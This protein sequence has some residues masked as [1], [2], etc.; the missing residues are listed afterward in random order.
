[1]S[2]AAINLKN[3]LSQETFLE[4]NESMSKSFIFLLSSLCDMI[5]DQN[6]IIQKFTDDSQFATKNDFKENEKFIKSVKEEIEAS[7]K[8][9]H[10]N[11]Q[12]DLDSNRAFQA[13]RMNDFDKQ[14]KSI[15]QTIHD[16][17]N[18]QFDPLQQ[19][20][21]EK[22]LVISDLQSQINSLML[23]SKSTNDSITQL[24][25]IIPPNPETRLMHFNKKIDILENSQKYAIKE[26]KDKNESLLEQIKELH[27]DDEE[28]RVELHN[29]ILEIEA[30]AKAM[31]TT[32]QGDDN[33]PKIVNGQ[34]DISPL[35]RGIYRD[36]RRLDGFNEMISM[37]R[38]ETE[39]V[40]NSMIELQE[41]MNS[42]NHVTHDLAMED[43]RIR[44][45]T[46]ERIR[47]IQASISDLE[48]QVG[49]IWTFMLQVAD[50]NNHVASN[51][52]NVI[53]QI[54]SILTSLSTRPLPILNDFTDVALECHA[55]HEAV[56]E[57]RT[58]FEGDREQ[59]RK[60]PIDRDPHNEIPEVKVP[61]MQRR[62]KPV[63][64]TIELPYEDL[65]DRAK[66]PSQ[67]IGDAFVQ[68]SL[69]E[70]RV[71]MN[72]VLRDN[73]Y[74]AQQFENLMKT[75]RENLD[76]KVDTPTIERMINKIHL[77]IGRLSKR[78]ETV[79]ESEKHIIDLLKNAKK[80][81]DPNGP[82]LK[83][84]KRIQAP[85]SSSLSFE[86]KIPNM[87]V[88][89]EVPPIKIGSIMKPGTAL[90]K[91]NKPKR[92]TDSS[93]TK[94]IDRPKSSQKLVSDI[95]INPTMQ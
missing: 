56:F 62:V 80:R 47:F 83:V 2:N 24:R 19:A 27:R 25:S 92:P 29:T 66:T 48:K 35:I 49:E 39:D 51:V 37:T 52:S 87:T 81:P 74:M 63:L 18:S 3:L 46:T 41:K 73:E 33:Q 70:L 54:Q 17:I 15:D 11:L 78:V 82:S 84:K 42:F 8:S 71:T 79:E 94:S 89:T 5:N 12:S 58:Q 6:K 20:L 72:E 23:T 10:N 30:K 90:I 21:A 75:M 14:F 44:A 43:D 36:S 57:K 68:R 45:M 93:S 13:T 26:L 59:F 32:Y 4:N 67:Q 85:T 65:R 76:L 28:M 60:I 1:M 38:M 9:V 91:D 95:V 88:P 34:V 31:P 61:I 53:E 69:E 50:N 22:D 64:D 40:V 77:L 86:K 16:A 55:L 7:I